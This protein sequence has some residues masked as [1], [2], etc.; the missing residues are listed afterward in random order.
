MYTKNRQSKPHYEVIDNAQD[1]AL[2]GY[3]SKIFVKMIDEE[4]IMVEDD[5]NPC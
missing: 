4:T 2:A 3:A 1:E 5:E